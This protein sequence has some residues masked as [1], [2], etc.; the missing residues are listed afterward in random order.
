MTPGE[1]HDRTFAALYG[2]AV[3]AHMRRSRLNDADA[4][5]HARQAYFVS[6]EAAHYANNILAR[7]AER[8]LAARAYG[9]YD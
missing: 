3:E 6:L 4:E 9:P 1:R 2:R 7:A 8:E 5:Y